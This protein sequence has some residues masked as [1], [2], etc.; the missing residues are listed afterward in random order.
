M[1]FKKK[2]LHCVESKLGGCKLAVMEIKSIDSVMNLAYHRYSLIVLTQ[3][4]C[5]GAAGG[6]LLEVAFEVEG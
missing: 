1:W 4:L 2:S 5:P 3:E 6:F